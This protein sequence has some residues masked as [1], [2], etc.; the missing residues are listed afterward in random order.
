M[1]GLHEGRG[2]RGSKA[3]RRQALHLLLTVAGCQPAIWRRVAVADAMALS[4]LHDIIQISFGWFDYQTHVFALD[5]ARYGNPV[6]RPELV[7]EDDRDISLAE[8]DLPAREFLVYDYQMGEGWRVEIRF[9]KAQPLPGKAPAVAVCLAGDR[10]GPVEDCGGV[11]AYHDMVAS[12][13]EPN[14]DLGREWREW[15]GPDYD[16]ETCDL[17][18]INKALRTIKL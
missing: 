15:V 6:K 16:P 3:P 2:G 8:L 18:A 12:L 4:G 13:R 14:T 7:I 10:A 1:I 11:E 5:D 17:V 9:E